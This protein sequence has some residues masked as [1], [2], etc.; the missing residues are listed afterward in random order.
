[1]AAP[2]AQLLTSWVRV[3]G[4]KDPQSCAWCRRWVGA[5]LPVELQDTYAA[6]H[7]EAGSAHD[8][9]CTLEPEALRAD[10]EQPDCMWA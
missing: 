8:C 2:P 10:P 6:R 1:M 9:R 3:Q 4:P 5:V 7:R